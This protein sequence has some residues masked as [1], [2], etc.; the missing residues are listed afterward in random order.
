MAIKAGATSQTVT[1]YITDTT[2]AALT[3]LAYNTASLTCYYVRA[4]AS[5]VAVTLATLAA[6]NSAWSSGGFKEIDS[7]NMPGFY[8]FDVPN[9][10]IATGV[11][12]VAF[13]FKGASGMS[14]YPLKID[15]VAYDPQQDDLGLT[16]PSVSDIQSGTSLADL[17]TMVTGD[18][19]GSAKFT[20]TALENVPSGNASTVLYQG[21]IRMAINGDP[22]DLL[23]VSR[24]ETKQYLC[25]LLDGDGQVLPVGTMDVDCYEL[26]SEELV[27]GAATIT[28]LTGD[29][30]DNK[31]TL[32]FEVPTTGSRWRIDVSRSSGGGT[33]IFPVEA[34]LR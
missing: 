33:D 18:G 17:A 32:A 24:G 20:T 13:L 21:T 23:Y 8:R 4:G 9:A 5:A 2:G 16:I 6:A 29:N 31:F 26:P 28:E 22:S 11:P 3:G 12:H 25:Q 10:A 34:V 7:T 14:P 27:T 1:L 30:P 15:L 19:G